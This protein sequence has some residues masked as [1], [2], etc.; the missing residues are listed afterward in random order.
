MSTNCDYS[1]YNL[2]DAPFGIF[3]RRHH[4]RMCG[5]IFCQEHSSNK[6]LLAMPSYID[7]NPAERLRSERVCQA[8]WDDVHIPGKGA[9]R[10]KWP[11]N[12][13]EVNVS[14]IE[15]EQTPVSTEAIRPRIALA[16][17]YSD[18]AIS[19]PPRS[20]SSADVQ[21]TH[22][23]VTGVLATYPLAS[24]RPDGSVSSPVSPSPGSLAR[25]TSSSTWQVTP[26][27]TPLGSTQGSTVSLMDL[28]RSKSFSKDADFVYEQWGYNREIFND[29]AES[30]EELENYQED[31]EARMKA[32]KYLIVDGRESSR[33]ASVAQVSGFPTYNNPV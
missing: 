15:V 30:D 14:V 4:C 25:S 7:V 23:T 27:V 2:C 19:L 24:C 33:C 13:E 5:G 31:D 26:Q 8:C 28:G 21:R 9:H 17:Y 12:C 20:P 10:T 32:R 6:L 3:Q 11:K 1:L 22:S 18:P 16:R 29:E